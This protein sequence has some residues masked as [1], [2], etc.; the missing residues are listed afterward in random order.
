[1]SDAE[2]R[3]DSVRAERFF[4][5]IRQ[6][7]KD[8]ETG[9]RAYVNALG[10][11]VFQDIMEHF[12]KEQGPQRKWQGW[13]KVY[14]QRMARVGKGGNK[15]LQDNGHLRQSFKPTS[16]L[17]RSKGI[18]WYNNAKTAKGF[19]Y[20]YAHN[21]GGPVMPKREFMWL[22]KK[23]IQRISALTAKWM[24]SGSEKGA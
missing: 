1:M 2:I 24:L 16:W 5:S 3:F 12:D 8:I 10:A 11:F 7:I 14:A 22:S 19:P 18:E 6:N 15:I 4:E 21:E 13:S 9:H 23:A 17:M 20:A